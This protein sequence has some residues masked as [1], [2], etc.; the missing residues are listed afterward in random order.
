MQGAHVE[1]TICHKARPPDKEVTPRENH[2]HYNL[3]RR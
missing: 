3:A 1:E 2:F